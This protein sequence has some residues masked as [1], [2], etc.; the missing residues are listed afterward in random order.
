[1][2]V[3]LLIGLLLLSVAVVLALRGLGA[4]HAR[5]ARLLADLG[6]YGFGAVP[7]GTQ[8]EH[9]ALREGLAS[10]SLRLGARLER[11]LGQGPAH[12][13]RVLL[14]SAGYYRTSV[15][16]YLG[17]RALAA[18]GAPVFLLLLGALG[19]SVGTALV[20]GGAGL[21]GLGWFGPPLVV[22]RRAR[23]RL[24]RIDHEV[25]ELVDLL[26]ATVEAGIGFAGALQICARRVRG[27]LGDELRLTLRE[28]SMG[29]TTNEAL[30]HLLERTRESVSMRAFVQAIVQGET[31]G[32][33]IGKVLRD[34]AVDMRGL[35][36]RLAE[37]RAQKAPVK[38][39]FPLVFLI[40]PAM[41]I[42]VMG[43][44]AYAVLH[45][46]NG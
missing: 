10:V 19:R 27:P 3:I 15:A 21:V 39:L 42:V 2:V 37:E 33:S 14:N 13:T 6:S 7:A 22:K 1:M 17:F 26:V 12:E 45:S 44:A 25:P 8:R 38:L 9:G 28:Q 30:G 5:D 32:V 4:A 16:R 20:L 40:L 43:P 46:L 24:A 29:L 41:V 34:L 36:R 23:Q 35:R 11:R 18:V 31:L